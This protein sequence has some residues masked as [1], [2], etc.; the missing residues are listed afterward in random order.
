MCDLKERNDN[1]REPTRTMIDRM[2]YFIIF[3]RICFD[4]LRYGVLLNCSTELTGKKNLHQR[5]VRYAITIKY[6]EAITVHNQNNN[7]NNFARDQPFHTQE[8]RKR[9]HNERGAR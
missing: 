4:V 2:R 9:D 6:E 7:N 5:F 8:I 3:V 1:N